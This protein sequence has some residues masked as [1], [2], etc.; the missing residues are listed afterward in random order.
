MKPPA[1]DA[2][3]RAFF[4]LIRAA[5]P[6]DYLA[7]YKGRVVAASR[8]DDLQMVDVEPEDPRLPP[9]ANVPLRLGIP[10]A[11]VEI[12]LR[13]GPERPPD[14]PKFKPT[15]VMIGWES[16]DPQK[17]YA[18]LFNPGSST[19]RLSLAAEKIELGGEGLVIPQEGA[20]NGMAV[21]SFTGMPQWMLGN[22]STVVGVKKN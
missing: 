12:D 3:K 1:A 15:F 8:V 11:F 14:A 21:D 22:A 16:G 5:N 6:T 9:M 4:S 10:G 2:M 20:I 19:L 7:F 13:Q 18:L 17:A